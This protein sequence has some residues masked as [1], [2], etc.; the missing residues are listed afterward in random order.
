MNEINLE[1]IKTETDYEN[2]LSMMDKIFDAEEGTP[3]ARLRDFCYYT[4][5]CM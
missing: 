1:P 3:E 5:S 2:A 4:S